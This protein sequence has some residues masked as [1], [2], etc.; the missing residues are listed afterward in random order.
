MARLRAKPPCPN[1]LMLEALELINDSKATIFV[2]DCDQ[3][4]FDRI[5]VD[6]VRRKRQ[7]GRTNN[8]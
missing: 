4:N 8:F 7:H 2:L 6:E 5:K 1:V 3:E